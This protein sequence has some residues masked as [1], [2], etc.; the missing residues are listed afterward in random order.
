LAYASG[1]ERIK[2]KAS[3]RLM[4]VAIRGKHKN[5]YIRDVKKRRS[6]ILNFEIDVGWDL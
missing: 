4:T 2:K 1:V 3:V 6:A 5:L